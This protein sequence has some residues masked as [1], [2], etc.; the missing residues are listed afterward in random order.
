M[1]LIILKRLHTIYFFVNSDVKFLSLL[2]LFSFALLN[3]QK[4]IDVADIVSEDLSSTQKSI[5][6]NKIETELVNLKKYR[7]TTRSEVDR[8]LK[9]QKFQQSGCTSDECIVEVGRMIGVERMVGGSI[10]KVGDLFSVNAKIVSVETGEIFNSITFDLNGEIEL[11]LSDGMKSVSY[12]LAGEEAPEIKQ[13]GGSFLS[14]VPKSIKFT[15]I[16]FWL[17]WGLLPPA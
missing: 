14:R 5:L 2:F 15:A 8:I 7:V 12:L 16:V 10:S 4:V 6:F 11:L 3:Q 13:L 9:E 1:Q 17:I